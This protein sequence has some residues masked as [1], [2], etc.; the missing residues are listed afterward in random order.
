MFL[1][2]KDLEKLI[3]GLKMDENAFI[4]AYCRWVTSPNGKEILSLREK[5]NKDCIFWDKKC[6]VYP[7]R[8]LQCESFPFWE[9]IVS[10]E[11]SWNMAASGCPGMNSGVTR[12]EKMITDSLEARKLEPII[13]RQARN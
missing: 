13:A 12:T 1:S 8:P 4:Y 2:R 5:S 10:S 9:S 6:E 7:F 3:V 11:R